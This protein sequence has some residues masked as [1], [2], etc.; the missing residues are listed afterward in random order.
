MPP[1]WESSC[2]VVMVTCFPLYNFCGNV[3]IYFCIGASTSSLSCS[4][5]LAVDEDWDEDSNN[6]LHKL[7][8]HKDFSGGRKTGVPGQGKKP[9]THTTTVKGKNQNGILP[10]L[11]TAEREG[12]GAITSPHPSHT[13][14]FC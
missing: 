2:L 10:M 3:G 5:S 12:L 11:G 13:H 9:Q 14:T 7:K 4:Y 1:R 8:L 6:F